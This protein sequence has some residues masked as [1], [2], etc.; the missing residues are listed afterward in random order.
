MIIKTIIRS[1]VRGGNSNILSVSVS[2]IPLPLSYST[3]HPRSPASI[4]HHARPPS[5]YYLGPHALAKQSSSSLIPHHHHLYHH[6]SSPTMLMRII[7]THHSLLQLAPASPACPPPTALPRGHTFLP[8]P[9]PSPHP[10]H[11]AHTHMCTYPAWR[12]A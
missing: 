6:H 2:Q 9:L 3:P 12:T 8:R 11:P 1:Y 10:P 4:M 7:I 5:P